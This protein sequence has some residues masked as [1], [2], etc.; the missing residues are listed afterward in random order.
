M[1]GLSENRTER[2]VL[3][4]FQSESRLRETY[5]SFADIAMK[6]GRLGTAK[7][8][9]A[10]AASED[11]IAHMLLRSLH[12]IGHATTELWAAGTFDTRKVSDSSRQ[13]LKTA[14]EETQAVLGMLPQMIE[15][16]AKDGAAWDLA[17]EFFGYADA[18][19][20]IHVKLFEKELAE[21][22]A[23][24]EKD[25]Y[26]CESCGNTMDCTP[27]ETCQVCGSSR[28]AFKKNQ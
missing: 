25:F 21:F 12:E 18:V 5:K 19:Q 28:S 24:T 23:R 13:N 27:C 1:A 15:D 6:E 14:L 9:R 11:V 3:K 16:T 4:T 2:N 8:F 26:V 22:D 7:L 10:T 20:R 17:R